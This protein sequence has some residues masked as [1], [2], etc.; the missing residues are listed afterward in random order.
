MTAK[1]IRHGDVALISV[2]EKSMHKPELEKQTVVLAEGEVTGHAHKLTGNVWLGKPQG[3]GSNNDRELVVKGVA[4]LTHEEHAPVEIAEGTWIVRQQ[5]E[6][7]G[8]ERR[9]VD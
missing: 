5:R 3:W 8:Q 6:F 4:Q 7:W 9:V 1:W 2:S